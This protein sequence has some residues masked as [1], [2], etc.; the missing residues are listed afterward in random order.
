MSNHPRILVNVPDNLVMYSLEGID[1]SGKT[2]QANLITESLRN[3][4][5]NAVY[6]HTPSDEIIGKFIRNN[7]FT[8]NSWQKSTLFLLDI[9]SILKKYKSKSKIL[10]WDRYTDSSIVSNWDLSPLEAKRWNECLPQTRKTF[11]LDIKPETIL[12]KRVEGPRFDTS[13]IEW[14]YLKYNRYLKLAEKEKDRIVIINGDKTQSEISQEIVDMIVK[15]LKT[16]NFWRK[17][18]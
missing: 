3:L 9:I 7:L 6:V 16:N 11:F 5:F 12:E 17:N 10:I 1:G 14:Q 4:G 18:G 2:T 15:N 8:L 13:D